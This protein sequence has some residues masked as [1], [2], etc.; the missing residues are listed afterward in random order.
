MGLDRVGTA[1]VTS[2]A[3]YNWR[4]MRFHWA[5]EL[6]P[7][8]WFAS[9]FYWQAGFPTQE[10]FLFNIRQAGYANPNSVQSIGFKHEDFKIELA[11]QVAKRIEWLT[12][13]RL[14][15][16]KPKLMLA[17]LAPIHRYPLQ[18]CVC[19]EMLAAMELLATPGFHPGRAGWQIHLARD[20]ALLSHRGHQ[21][22]WP[23]HELVGKVD[24]SRVSGEIVVERAHR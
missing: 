6:T 16:S 14:N 20:R 21:Q 3:P 5:P 22:V 4:P 18:R 11:K 17:L 8:I 9:T 13:H 24:G 15:T 7:G 23:K 1:R 12:H 10:Q 2:Y 19:L